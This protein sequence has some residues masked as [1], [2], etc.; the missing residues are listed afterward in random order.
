MNMSLMVPYL[1]LTFEVEIEWYLE[2]F[3]FGL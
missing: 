3:S 1:T 2:E